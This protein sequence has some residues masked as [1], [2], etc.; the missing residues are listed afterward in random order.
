[1]TFDEILTQVLDLLQRERRVSYRA[2]KR[3]FDLDDGYLEDLK[4]EIIKAKQLGADEAGEVL[5]WAGAGTEKEESETS[6]KE[7]PSA[8]STLVPVVLQS[9]TPRHLADKILTAKSALEGERRQV[10]V[11]FADMKGF[12]TLAEHLDPE[13]VHQIISHCFELITSEVHRF[14][15]TIN[16][17]YRRWRD[18]T[19]RRSDCP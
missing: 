7:S 5:V 3:R 6:H 11:L 9:Y 10:T 16:Q 14:E 18:G 13:E 12:T 15:G 2:L 19:I 8:S 4:A 1:M 17:L